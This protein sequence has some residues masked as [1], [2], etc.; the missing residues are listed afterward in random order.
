MKTIISKSIALFFVVILALSAPIKTNAADDITGNTHEADIRKMIELGIMIGYGEGQ[1]KPGNPVTRAQFATMLTRALKLPTPERASIFKDVSNDHLSKNELMAAA[2]A[3]LIE[4][5]NGYF[6]P[7][8]HISRQ[9]MAIMMHRA[10]QYKEIK[11]RPITLTFKDKADINKAYHAAVGTTVYYGIFQG[12]GEYFKPKNNATRGHGAAAISRFLQVIETGE[13]IL[14]GDPT[15]PVEE[16]PNPEPKPDPKPEPEVLDYSVATVAKNGKTTVVKQYKTYAEAEKAATSGQVVMHKN[17]IVKMAGGIVY[18]RGTA[19]SSTANI[20]S[21]TAMKAAFT[22]VAGDYELEYVRSTDKLVEVKLAGKTGYMKHENAQLIPWNATQGRSYYRT[23]NGDLVHYLYSNNGK[24]YNSYIA[25]KAPSFMTAGKNYYS[26]NGSYF[27]DENGKYVG[28][29]YQY[30]QYLPA[31]SKTVYSAAQIDAYIVKQLKELERLYPTSALYKNASTKSKLL[32]LGTYLKQVEA[33]HKVN[34]MLILSL[35]QH[36]S[37]YGM[38][39]RA[40]NYNNLFGIR[41]FDDNPDPLVF[42]T[43]A[44]NID[45]L[46]KSYFNKNYIPPTAPYAYGGAFGNKAHG[47]NVKYASDPFWGSKAAGHW[48]RAD[49]MMGGQDL[50]NAQRIALTNTPGLNIRSGASTSHA[51]YFTYRY[52]QM[53]VI[54]TSDVSGSP[55]K[56]IVSDDSKYNEAFVHGNY[57]T[58]IPVVTTK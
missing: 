42:P 19:A 58:E 26:W 40:Q 3:K 9:H 11:D 55:W 4:G 10:L 50:R 43:I 27:N 17:D 37:A 47:F 20:Y 45:E 30:F 18:S 15:P 6:K 22:Y 5:D 7:N 41:V 39:D 23:V 33:T 38:S 35:A 52:S 21:D 34:A 53:P 8:N 1:F 54:I 49:K 46:M 28:Q 57:L 51:A 56:K 36:E 32:G 44:S 14:P 29:A 13:S 48:Y 12:D 25:G 2:D 16:K 31:R 24:K